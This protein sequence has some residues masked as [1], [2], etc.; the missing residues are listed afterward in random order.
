VWTIHNLG[1]A[2]AICHDKEYAPCLQY[3]GHVL[4]HPG[5]FNLCDEDVI[6]VME[7]AWPHFIPALEQKLTLPFIQDNA[8]LTSQLRCTSEQLDELEDKYRELCDKNAQLIS[9]CKA[10]DKD[11][12]DDEQEITH[13]QAQLACYTGSQLQDPHAELPMKR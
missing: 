9:M 10:K 2:I 1:E 11:Q 4:S 12:Q 7:K 5:S 13:L 8:S 6:E 3:V